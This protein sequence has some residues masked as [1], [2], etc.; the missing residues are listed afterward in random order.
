MNATLG[1]GMDKDCSGFLSNDTVVDAVTNHGVSEAVVDNALRHSLAVTFRLGIADPPSQNPF[2]APDG[3]PTNKSAIINSA[4]H[5]LLAKD[6]A[7]QGLVLLKNFQNALPWSA[8]KIRRVAVIGRMADAEGPM[9]GNYR[10]VPPQ[11]TTVCEGIAA[12]A[13]VTA[14][15]NGSAMI[16]RSLGKAPH[17]HYEMQYNASAAVDPVKAV[18]ALQGAD[19]VVLVVGTW[20]RWSDNGWT[21][22]EGEGTDRNH[23]L[24]PLNQ[25]ALVATVA[26]AATKQQIPVVVVV[27]S[28]GP[29]DL[30]AEKA[31]PACPAII[32]A[33]FPGEHGGASIADAIFGTDGKTGSIMP[34]RFGKL[35]QTWYSQNFVGESN[36]TDFRMRPGP[37][38]C[39][40]PDNCF[41]KTSGR[42][43]RFYT[44]PHATWPFGFGLATTVWNVT[45]IQIQSVA[46]NFLATLDH[47]EVQSKLLLSR[48]TGHHTSALVAKVEV[49]VRNCGGRD[50]DFVA[51]LFARPPGAGI[52]GT[53]RQVLLDFQRQRVLQGQSVA[54]QFPLRA[55]HFAVVDKAGAWA[56]TPG[57]WTFFLRDDALSTEISTAV[58]VQQSFADEWPRKNASK[59]AY[60]LYMIG[61]SNMHA[62]VNQS[63]IKQNMTSE[64]AKALAGFTFIEGTY[65]SSEIQMIRAINPLAPPQFTLYVESATTSGATKGVPGFTEGLPGFEQ[66]G[67]RADAR[68]YLQGNLSQPLGPGDRSLTLCSS[69]KYRNRWPAPLPASTPNSSNVST[70]VDAQ[71]NGGFVSFIRVEAELIKVTSAENVSGSDHEA[72]PCQKLGVQRGLD[73]TVVGSY[74]K[75]AVVLAPAYAGGGPPS[76][77][78]GASRYIPTYHPRYNSTYGVDH[79]VNWTRFAIAQGYSGSWLDSF[80]PQPSVG[81]QDSAGNV[82]TEWNMES[83][84]GGLMTFPSCM[85]QQRARLTRIWAGLQRHRETSKAILLANDGG[86]WEPSFLTASAGFRPLDG[87]CLEAWGP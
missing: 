40:T 4:A 14:C 82:V 13:T 9:L 37:A 6:A 63:C 41:R 49:S 75:G 84:E 39:P 77:G 73:S 74:P 1:A 70:R 11:F 42:G 72:S 45:S 15:I 22:E 30:T 34:S 35:S 18:A 48:A 76:P 50:G 10:G 47:T 38:Y 59:T 5:Q 7:D 54:L 36:M 32:W 23:L 2:N 79:Y 16:N 3:R 69:I 25:S 20:A 71:G 65:D 17:I 28:G 8:S 29:V 57:E 66:G 27:M 31:S 80:H 78:A 44:G 24:L 19:A 51:L 83:P 53:P 64:D 86:Q 55:A 62:C 21:G 52:N 12:H 81:V 33:G 61:S 60:P 58:I 26:A 68:F 67:F 43:H 87:Y 46:G 56:V 85:D